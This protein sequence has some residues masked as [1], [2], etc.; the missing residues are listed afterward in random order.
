MYGT[1]GIHAAGGG[2]AYAQGFSA[3]D[4]LGGDDLGATVASN[5]MYAVANG[6]VD[7]HCIDTATTIIRTEDSGTNNY[8]I[9][10]HLLDNS[11]LRTGYTF[12][13]GDY[14]GSLKYGSFDENC[15]WAE[16]TPKHYHLHFGFKPAS[17]FFTMEGCTLDMSSEKWNCG[18][19]KI[20]NTGQFIMNGWTGVPTAGDDANSYSNLTGFWDL[21]L[22]GA[23]SI[24]GEMVIDNMPD[25]TAN[26]FL[27]ALYN[28]VS[29]A[30]RIARV[31][32][33]S[34][35]NLGHLVTA[36]VF[37]FGIKTVLGIAEF[38]IFLLKAWKSIVPVIGA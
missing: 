7:Y 31:I 36:V 33:Y 22:T 1:R 28:G 34:N 15:G 13:Q 27:Y 12:Y 4:F 19:G 26:Q 17:G 11:N 18:N 35:I 16:Q 8:Y 37:G 2:A 10:A 21:I 23:S 3:V 24:W 25:H 30:V 20:V 32:L 6:Q 38:V 29:V 5:R 14:I 9:Y